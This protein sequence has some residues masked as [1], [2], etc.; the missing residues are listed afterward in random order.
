MSA[1]PKPKPVPRVSL[2]RSTYQPSKAEKEEEVE[3]PE[4]TPEDLAKAVVRTVDV[5]WKRR[6]D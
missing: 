5:D 2:V 4:G 3:F 1:K 6:P